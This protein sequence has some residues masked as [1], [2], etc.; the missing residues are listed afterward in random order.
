M[1]TS[2]YPKLIVYSLVGLSAA[3]IVAVALIARP[4]WAPAAQLTAATWTPPALPDTPAGRQLSGFLVAFNSGKEEELKRYITEHFTPVGPGGSNIATR[5]NSQL[6]LYNASRGLSVYKV[7][8]SSDEAI[9]IEAQF[10]LTQEWRRMTFAVDSAPGHRI[11]GIQIVPIEAPAISS[12]VPQT[13]EQL[14]QQIDLFV[15]GLVKA[16]QFSGVVLVAKESVPLFERA[17]GLANREKDVANQTSTRFSF[18][19]VGKMFTAVA[20]AQLVEQGKLNYD[21]P[22]DQLLPD[23]A[24]DVAAKITVD[25]LLTH[26]SGIPDFF[27]D[28]EAFAR[29]KDSPDPQRDYVSVFVN[30]PLRFPPGERFEYS[31]SNYII[32]GA[33]VERLSGLAF[34]EYLRQHVFAPAG[35]T[36]TSLSAEGIE[37][38]MLATKYTQMDEDEQLGLGPRRPSSIS[39]TN[40]G[41]AAGGGVTTARD[42]WKFDRALRTHKLLSAA[43]TQQL[44]I[45]R[46]DYPRPGYRYGYG[47]I[48]RRA[49][50]EHVA[51]HSGGFPGV[52]AQFDM[53]LDSGYTIIVLAN[54]ELV[55]EPVTLYIQRLLGRS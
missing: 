14:R 25:Q 45:D 50:E 43:A 9:T 37:E 7:T 27:A 55:A 44:L 23:Y 4:F 13:D 48:C 32:L 41:S 53:Y 15:Q 31:N 33:I 10:P 18:A 12:T 20:I 8:E 42:L 11:S 6:R 54:Y 29:V 40:N 16:D 19:S 38:Q 26:R 35:M 22:F 28:R 5:I 24:S 3:A 2:H 52:D 51:G 46:V 39:G 1:K 47:F 34:P 30:E 36:Q 17:Y 49:G 21:Q